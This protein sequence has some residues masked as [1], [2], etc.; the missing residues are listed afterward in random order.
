MSAALELRDVAYIAGGT[1]TLDHVSLS[2]AS[3][4]RLAVV[5]E[6]GAGK[7][8]LARIAAAL[9]PPLAGT[10]RLFGVDPEALT[11]ESLRR[12]RSRISVVAQGGSLLGE[13]TVEE[14]L[15]LGLGAVRMEA[16][17]RLRR[18]IDRL[19]VNFGLETAYDCRA[20]ALSVG[21]QRRLELA[22]AFLREPEL[23]ILDD[24]LQGADAATAADLERRLFRSLARRPAAMLL[25]T[26]DEALA[27]RLCERT[28][29]LV[30]GTLGESAAA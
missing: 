17:P 14:N 24:P 10:V 2:L 28:A 7:S 19:V 20:D 29:M 21:E 9:E 30:R 11:S 1:R 25:L 23:L 6:N 22:R 16:M 27:R 15:R 13:L 26:H 3:G 8:T 12:L 4:E 18:R 5:G